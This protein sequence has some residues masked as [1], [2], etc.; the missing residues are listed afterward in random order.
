MG[1][2]IRRAPRHV[3][4]R[5]QEPSP[6]RGGRLFAHV[7]KGF[8]AL[9]RC[10]PSLLLALPALAP[11]CAA[12]V[13]GARLWVDVDPLGRPPYVQEMVLLRIRGSFTMPITLERLEQPD[14]AGFRW[15]KVGRDAWYDTVQDGRQARGFQRTLAVYPQRSGTLSIAPFVHHLTI[16]DAGGARATL[17][18]A[19]PPLALAVAPAPVPKEAW[20][21][22]AQGLTMTDT[23]SADPETLQPGQSVRRTVTIEAQ[24]VTDDQLPPQPAIRVPQLI[25]FPDEPQRE[26]VIGVAPVA[27]TGEQK[28]Q[29]LP[30]PGR[31]AEVRGAD[32]PKAKVAYAWE[33][34]PTSDRAVDLPE[35]RIP[36]FDTGR[37]AMA[38]AV[39][40]ARTV[41]IAP[42]GPTLA[43]MERGLGIAAA[44]G[45]ANAPRYADWTLAAMAFLL[46]LVASL[47]L[48]GR[49]LGIGALRQR[50]HAAL[51]LRRT[52]GAL[53]AS[54]AAG[55]P[56]EAWQALRR[57]TAL[58]GPV[59]WLASP[60]AR[61]AAAALEA[62]AFGPMS[63]D[64]AGV[65]SA[66]A[67]LLRARRRRSRS[68]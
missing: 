52:L 36:W 15:L 55:R 53:S 41:A 2:I 54:A 8:A 68:N 5:V 58:D 48:A 57:L 25:A 49:S 3:P 51:D 43:E 27:A 34:R 20:W 9:A 46:A 14:L 11:A 60:E 6:R 22:P 45:A 26:T 28:R 62:A 56:A 30:K 59:G 39:L 35:I 18:L 32:G 33:I 50:L 31:L 64:A 65:R 21:L 61:S 17:E 47:L 7:R 19:T 37:N 44:A 1:W 63:P 12:D 66:A 40:P 42:A 67:D 10:I 29:T 38:L 23:W 16:L 13:P 24:G 4:T